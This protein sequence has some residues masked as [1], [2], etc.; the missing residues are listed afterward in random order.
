MTKKPRGNTS[1][2]AISHGRK[3]GSAAGAAGFR[4]T[5]R[6]RRPAWAEV[7]GE[8]LVRQVDAGYRHFWSK[9]GGVPQV[10]SVSWQK[11]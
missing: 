11:Y 3:T 4:R 8:Q 5:Q 1:G 6:R 7:L 10:E 2:I 9:R